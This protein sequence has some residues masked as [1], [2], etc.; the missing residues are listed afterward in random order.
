MEKRNLVCPFLRSLGILHLNEVGRTWRIVLGSA[1]PTPPTV[2]AVS[3][4]FYWMSHS[5]LHILL[6]GGGRQDS[7]INFV[8]ISTCEI[9]KGSPFRNKPEALNQTKLTSRWDICG[10]L[11]LSTGMYSCS[12]PTPGFGSEHKF[13]EVG[14]GGIFRFGAVC[15]DWVFHVGRPWCQFLNQGNEILPVSNI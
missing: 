9:H 2:N 6:M 14:G 3:A 15:R 13:R 4:A 1:W 11:D 12:T 8:A 5:S 7:R 10:H